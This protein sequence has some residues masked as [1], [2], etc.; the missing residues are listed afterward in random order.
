[1]QTQKTFY[2]ILLINDTDNVNRNLRSHDEISQ[3]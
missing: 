3:K 1:M 2:V